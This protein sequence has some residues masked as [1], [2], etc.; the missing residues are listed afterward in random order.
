M[1]QPSP[2]SSVPEDEFGLGVS[3]VNSGLARKTLH[4]KLS[5]SVAY[6]SPL[7]STPFC[8]ALPPLMLPSIQNA[9]ES[10]RLV[11]VTLS[12]M[13]SQS[14]RKADRLSCNRLS[15]HWLLMPAS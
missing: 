10:E 13:S 14:M 7:N 9:P 2:V 8:S 6:H 3:S 5:R 4:W 12:W 15:N 1:V 11:L